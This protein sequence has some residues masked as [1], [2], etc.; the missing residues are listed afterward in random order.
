M[1]AFAVITDALRRSPQ[2]L[3]QILRER[4]EHDVEADTDSL[5]FARARVDGMLQIG[6]KYEHRSVLHSHDDLIGI[7]GRE[8]DDRWPDDPALSAWVMEVD[9]VRTRMGS[10]VVHAAQEVIGVLVHLVC[11]ASRQDCRPAGGDFVRVATDPE[12]LQNSWHETVHAGKFMTALS[13]CVPT[14]QL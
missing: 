9:C 8:L 2:R 7:L 3:A 5:F 1:R 11:R 4:R 14:M 12:E 10:D 6:R 13:E